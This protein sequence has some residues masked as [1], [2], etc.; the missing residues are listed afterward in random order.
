MKR[1]DLK[2][3]LAV[4]IVIACVAA[5]PS[6]AEGGTCPPGYYPV[7]GSGSVGCAPL[8]SPGAQNRAPRI[9]WDSRSGALAMDPASGRFAAAER[10]KSKRQ[11]RRAALAECGEGCKI[12]TTYS[13]GCMALVWGAGT[14]FYA[15]G[16]DRAAA[17]DHAVQACSVEAPN[18]CSV[19][20][21]GCSYPVRVR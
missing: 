19:S 8:S 2:F 1:I 9:R 3:V 5:G 14:S 13:N 7:G 10:K 21:S 6:G 15:S 12:L 16:P 11:A 20:Y 18:Q 4:A 17:E